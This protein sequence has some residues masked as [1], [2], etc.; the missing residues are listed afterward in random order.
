M[1]D[2]APGIENVKVSAIKNASNEV[3]ERVYRC[4]LQLLDT[5]ANEWPRETKEGWVI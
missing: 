1:R 3:K 2:G 4:V 5:P